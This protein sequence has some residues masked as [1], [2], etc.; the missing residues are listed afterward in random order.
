MR[1]KFCAVIAAL[2]LTTACGNDKKADPDPTIE[3][4]TTTASS[5]STGIA[6][7]EPIPI[8]LDVAPGRV[9]KVHVGMTKNQAAATGYFDTDVKVGG[10]ECPR[11]EPLQ[12]KKVYQD[13]V[14]VLTDDDNGSIVAMGIRGD[15]KTD[16]G[17]GVGNTLAAINDVYGDAASPAEEA[18]YTQTGVY[19]NTGDDWL[20]FLVNAEF[21]KVKS[22]SKVT[23]MEVSKGAKPGLM[24]DGC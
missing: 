8:K 23:F 3:A 15:L 1:L 9:G 5:Q 4:P 7:G 16:K 12:W 24:R 18:G 11:I 10:E 19:V 20:G 17:V 21:T 13:N 14:D 6:S 22:T 2:L